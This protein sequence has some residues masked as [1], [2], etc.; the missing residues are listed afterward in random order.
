MKKKKPSD[1]RILKITDVC[2]AALR[3]GLLKRE[4]HLWLYGQRAFSEFTV[5]RVIDSGDGYQIGEFVVSPHPT[6]PPS[7]RVHYTKGGNVMIC[8]GNLLIGGWTKAVTEGPGGRLEIMTSMVTPR[9]TVNHHFVDNNDWCREEFRLDGKLCK[10]LEDL[11][12]KL[13]QEPPPSTKL[14]EVA[15]SPSSAP[16]HKPAEDEWDFDAKDPPEEETTDDEF[17]EGVPMPAPAPEQPA[18]V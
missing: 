2:R 8:T 7:K 4:G 16:E 14:K 17:A 9:V 11:V 15:I 5:A 3:S 1:Y 18:A 12:E 6:K 10:S 13:N